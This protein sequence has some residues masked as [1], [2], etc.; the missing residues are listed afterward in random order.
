[1][2]IDCKLFNG[3]G[4]KDD[5]VI[6][7]AKTYRYTNVKDYGVKADGTTD[8]YKTIQAVLDAVYTSGGGIVWLPSSNFPY[9]ISSTLRIPEG[10]SLIGDG[11][12]TTVIKLMRGHTTDTLCSVIEM[13]NDSCV[14]H[15][16]VD[17][18]Y[19]ENIDEQDKWDDNMSNPHIGGDGPPMAHGISTGLYLGRNYPDGRNA[20]PSNHCRINNVYIHDTI[21]TCLYMV[22]KHHVINTVHLKNSYTDHYIY[23]SGAE[24]TVR[25]VYCTGMVRDSGIVIGARANV[26]MI[27]SVFEN[28]FIE[29]MTTTTW[30]GNTQYV[31]R[32]INLRPNFGR[33]NILRNIRIYDDMVNPTEGA[34]V[35]LGQPCTVLDGCH[36]KVTGMDRAY[37][38]IDIRGFS[39]ADGCVVINNTF[40]EMYDEKA[41]NTGRYIL[42][43]FS[44]CRI[45]NS[46][47]TST[48]GGL[49]KGI[50]ANG[51]DHNVDI[52]IYGVTINT[53][54]DPLTFNGEINNVRYGFTGILSNNTTINTIGTVIKRWEIR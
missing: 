50:N 9:M 10:I 17:G 24:I 44:D 38:L 45:S 14:E 51:S 2:L 46:S 35:F 23:T 28:I 29:K 22:G 3:I 52:E 30:P 15:L 6:L 25:N 26:T 49:R 40:V 7:K 19:S 32:A 13:G 12:G 43:A 11:I 5:E 48:D 47:F 41:V 31:W 36:M 27:N 39:K 16:E 42:R 33:G 34:S 4:Y 21:R 37:G 53:S 18:N 8:D 1:M 20:S 54:C